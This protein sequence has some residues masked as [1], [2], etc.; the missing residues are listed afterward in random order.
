M[1]YRNDRSANTI[2]VR[3][4]LESQC[5]VFRVW[6]SLNDCESVTTAC[7]AFCSSGRCTWLIFDTISKGQC[8]SAGNRKQ[9]SALLVCGPN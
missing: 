3:G 1:S 5:A 2:V 9:A 4:Q 7:I 6:L 8:V